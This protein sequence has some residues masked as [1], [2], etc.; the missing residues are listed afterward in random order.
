[1]NSDIDVRI[2]EE[3]T[4]THVMWR[5]D[6]IVE[7]LEPF[8]PTSPPPKDLLTARKD[9]IIEFRDSTRPATLSHG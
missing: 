9:T 8:Q 4:L 3:V 6:T 5:I 2:G 1:M 7:P